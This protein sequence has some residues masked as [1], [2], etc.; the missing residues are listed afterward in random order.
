MPESRIAD[1][2]V[3]QTGRLATASYPDRRIAFE[4]DR[5]TPVA[6]VVDGRNVF[7]VRV[8]LIDP[9]AW[10]RP[11]MGGRPASSPVAPT[12]AASSSATSPTG[13]MRLW[14]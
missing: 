14:W 13:C 6:E 7:R 11:G 5:I 1:V 8:R 2:E 12:S 9:P 4:V 10:L 3:G